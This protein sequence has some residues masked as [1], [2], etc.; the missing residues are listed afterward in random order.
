MPAAVKD[1]F[2]KTFSDFRFL[3]ASLEA[4]AEYYL[5]ALILATRMW[6]DEAEHCLPI[7][8]PKHWDQLE[9]DMLA[10]APREFV[11][12]YFHRQVG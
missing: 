12:N 1:E 9:K 7:H 5:N 6:W 2:L 8:D 11:R 3:M 4:S 10:A